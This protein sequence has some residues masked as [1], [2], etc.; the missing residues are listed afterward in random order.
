MTCKRRSQIASIYVLRRKAHLVASLAMQL[1]MQDVPCKLH[2]ALP[3]QG[4]L[5]ARQKMTLLVSADE[6]DDL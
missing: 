3:G 5:T 2:G 1:G 6:Y 4:K